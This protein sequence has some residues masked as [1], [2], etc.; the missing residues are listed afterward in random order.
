MLIL[1]EVSKEHQL[2]KPE[3]TV[4]FSGSVKEEVLL[5]NNDGHFHL[6][7]LILYQLHNIV[8]FWC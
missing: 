7:K 6:S 3:N 1:I 8:S 2:K 4:P 5:V